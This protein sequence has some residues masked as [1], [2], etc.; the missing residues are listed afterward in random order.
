MVDA[1]REWQRSGAPHPPVAQLIGFALTHVDEG[2][3]T[4]EMDASERHWSPTAT[5]HGGILCS[6]ADAAMGTAYLSKLEVGDGCSTLELKIN[7]LRPFWSGHLVAK[8]WVV[9]AGKQVG[10]LAC[11]ITDDRGRLIA[12]ATSTC[13]AFRS[14]APAENVGKREKNLSPG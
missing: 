6:I 4:V 10:L 7:Y 12:H 9:D 5:V 3:A 8:G 14:E 1:L 2:V 13:M 11:D